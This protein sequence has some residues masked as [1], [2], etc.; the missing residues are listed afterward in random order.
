M[1][2]PSQDGQQ[3]WVV[4]VEAYGLGRRTG[5]GLGQHRPPVPRRG[6]RQS[7]TDGLD[8][9]GVRGRLLEQGQPEQLQARPVLLQQGGTVT[10]VGHGGI[11]QHQRQVVRQFAAQ[12]A[13]EPTAPEARL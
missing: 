9:P 3:P 13:Q 2:T 5:R 8:H 6:T 11:L 7:G 4:R 12:I 10:R 1:S